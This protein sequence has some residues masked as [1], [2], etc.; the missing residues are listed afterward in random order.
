MAK[1]NYNALNIWRGRIGGQVYK[2]VRGKQVIAPFVAPKNPNTSKQQLARAKMAFI[3]TL[4][5]IFRYVIRIGFKGAAAS[6]GSTPFGRFVKENY[7][8]MTGT[9]PGAIS[10]LP[11]SIVVAKGSRTGASFSPNIDTDSTPGKVTLNITDATT[12][13]EDEATDLIYGAL[14]APDLEEAIVSEGVARTEEKIEIAYP[15][16]WSGLQIHAYGFVSS[17]DNTSQSQSTYI[18]SANLD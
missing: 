6:H 3:G 17:A 13:Y 5:T 14:Y 1:A 9:Q 18:G 8:S 7:H 15:A 10:I 16:K 4:A 11:S 2:N 12:V